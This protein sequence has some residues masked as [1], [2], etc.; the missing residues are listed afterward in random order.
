MLAVAVAAL[1]LLPQAELRVRREI[2]PVKVAR[3]DAAVGVIKIANPGRRRTRAVTA[4]DCC[5]TRALPVPVPRLAPGATSTS[6]YRLPTDR[7]GEIALGPLTLLRRD[8]F[9]FFQRG[10]DHGERVTLV[11]RP[12][13]VPLAPLA[14]GRVASLDGLTAD[15][16]PS[17]TTTFHALREYVFGDDLRHIHWRTTA[18]AGTL[19]VRQLVDASEP[20][21]TVVLDTSRDAYRDPDDFEAA[22]DVAASVAAAATGAGFPVLVVTPAGQLFSGRGGRVAADQV[23]DRLALAEPGP[24]GLAEALRH[25][26]SRSAGGRHTDGALAVVTGHAPASV[27]ERVA[28]AGAR[29]QRSVTVRVGDG[30]PPLPAVFA[31]PVLDVRDAAALGG[32][33]QRERCQ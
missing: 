4:A 5:G 26:D 3:G 8:P 15:T 18:R 27:L 21:T 29:Y 1:W 28:V 24:A 25:V 6:T 2:A 20:L 30:L 23:L 13:V 19:M 22:V 11:V 12:R 17:G 33:W 31:L 7:R 32:A 9:G 14:S 16:A 10:T